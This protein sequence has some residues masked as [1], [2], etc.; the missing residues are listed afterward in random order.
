MEIRAAIVDPLPLYCH[1]AAAAM[2]ELGFVIDQPADIWSW[3]TAATRHIVLL[4][5]CTS[6]D[7]QLL[8]DLHAAR[9]DVYLL[10]LVSDAT[11]ETYIRALTGGAVGVVPRAGTPEALRAAFSSLA[12]GQTVLPVGVIGQLIGKRFWPVQAPASEGPH[13]ANPTPLWEPSPRERDWLRQLA[14]GTTVAQLAHTAGYSERMMFRLL[15]SLYA[16]MATSN[17][18]EAL[19]L[20]RDRGWI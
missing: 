13:S 11:P 8:A 6:S 18:T 19:M 20:A 9:P 10:A 16:R 3:L 5:L 1:G 15:R 7:W 2:H 4:S 17:R 14:I 12:N